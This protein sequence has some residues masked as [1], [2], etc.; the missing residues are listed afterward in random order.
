M[1]RFVRRAEWVWTRPPAELASPFQPAPSPGCEEDRNRYV[2][3]RRSFSI[4]GTPTSAPVFVSADG[5]YQLFVNG[6]RVGRGPGRC[7]PEYQHVDPYDVSRYLQ[8]GPNVIACLVHTYGADLAWYV[9]RSQLEREVFGCGGF[10][11]QGDITVPAGDR[12]A[13]R[14]ETFPSVSLDTGDG[15]W[16]F[17]VSAAWNPDTAIAGP[18][19]EEEFS[20]DD[21][22]NGWRQIECDVTDWG[23]PFVQKSTLPLGE[24][25]LRPFPRM[26]LPDA[27]ALVDGEPVRPVSVRQLEIDTSSDG[28]T[29]SVLDFGR[30]EMGRLF[31]E[32]ESAGGTEL[33]FVY[34]ERLAP[35]GSALVPDRVAGISEPPFHRVRLGP[36]RRRFEQFEPA[37]FRYAEVRLHPQSGE[38]LLVDA[39][40]VPSRYPVEETGRFRCS[41][42]ELNEVWEGCALTARLCRQDGFIDCPHR[43]QRQ[44]TG[45]AHIQALLGY[46]VHGDPRPA[47]RMLR[48]VAE[49]QRADGMVMMA[50]VS[51]LSAAGK[52][53][54]PEFGL[55]WVLAMETHLRYAGRA[56][57]LA[58]LVPAAVHLLAWFCDFVDDDGLLADIPGWNFVDWSMELDRSGEGTVMNAVFVG[59]VRALETVARAVGLELLMDRVSRVAE[60]IAESINQFL[61]D[62]VRGLYADARHHGVLS[63]VFSQH[64][65]AAVI[66]F[67]IAPAERWQGIVDAIADPEA[68]VLTRA[69]RFDIER[70]FDPGSQIVRAQPFFSHFVHDAYARVGA[71]GA[72]LSSIQGRWLPMIRRNGTAWEQWQDT[73]TTSLCHGFSATPLYDLPTHVVGIV[74]TAPGFS[75]FS[76][77]PQLGNLTFAEAIMPT[78]RGEIVVRWDEADDGTMNLAITVPAGTV[79]Q[80]APPDGLIGPRELASGDHRVR[81]V[82]A[83]N[84]DG[85]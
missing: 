45:D 83:G 68:V 58:P 54:I 57:E 73:P 63:K 16:R 10:F 21:E 32:V 38:A 18:G 74:P 71:I 76:V 29:I 36:G 72:L 28:E 66:A 33:T 69:W 42:P 80:I 46:M 44:W 19:F 64:A 14:G 6:R 78:P 70:P 26:V 9:R 11:F 77:R 59:A 1:A 5:R 43:E 34:S 4:A 84:E 75:R 62:D 12:A 8:P 30:T 56:Q 50:T 23:R 41:V 52:L 27:A 82:S 48:Q 40:V 60:R 7:H 81:Y 3:F 79:A 22:P 37:G 2:Y 15:Q 20:S 31:F 65:N 13:S 55:W 53:Y 39:G 24:T 61:F 85:N 51:D 25:V 49:T 17:L 35:D 47:E 67:G